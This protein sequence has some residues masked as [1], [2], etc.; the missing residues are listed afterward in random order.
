MTRPWDH[1]MNLNEMGVLDS[2]NNP[3]MSR[4]QVG[5]AGPCRSN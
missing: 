4:W 1:G 5:A 2:S 3:G